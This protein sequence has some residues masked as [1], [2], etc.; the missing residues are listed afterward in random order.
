MEISEIINLDDNIIIKNIKTIDK[1]KLD[2]YLLF[3]LVLFKKIDSIKYVLDNDLVRLDMLDREGKTILYNIIKFNYIDL[4]DIILEKNKIL[5]GIDLN[6]VRDLN[7]NISLNYTIIFNNIEM[8]K[9]LILLFDPYIKNKLNLNSFE[10]SVK[11]KKYNI[12]LMLVDKY[13][14]FRFVNNNNENILFDLI[15]DNQLDIIKTLIKRENIK[16]D[17]NLKNKEFSLTPLVVALGNNYSDIALL[18][19]E[20]GSDIN[21]TDNFGNTGLHYLLIENNINIFNIV[22]EYL[23]NKK[24]DI[25]YDIQ[26][27]NGNT[28]LHLILLNNLENKINVNILETIIKNTN[29]NLLNQDSN[30]VLL[31]IIKNKLLLRFIDIIKDKDMNFLLKIDDRFYLDLLNEEELN[32][33]LPILKNNYYKALTEEDLLELLNWEKQC[34]DIKKE[35]KECLDLIEKEIKNRIKLKP[36]SKQN[37]KLDNGILINVND[38]NN[39]YTGSS[40]DIIYGLIYL[41]KNYSNIT[42]FLEYPLTVNEE[43]ELFYKRLNIDYPFN[44]DFANFEII[45]I[46]NNLFIPNGLEIEKIK[47][48][49]RFYVIPIA[50]DSSEFSHANML[51]I[52]NE[53][54]LIERFEPFGINGPH[55][56]FY[57]SNLLDDNLKESFE[58]LNYKYKKPIDYLPAVSFQAL[59]NLEKPNFKKIGDPNGFCAIWCSW[60]VDMKLKY[61]FIDSKSLAI[62]LLEQFKIDKIVLSDFIRD[63]SYNIT[64]LRDEILKKNNIDINDWLNG[65]YTQQILD[66]I[67]KDTFNINNNF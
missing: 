24:V 14:D 66:N 48:N 53:N 56:F 41:S 29:L 27:L 26:N 20:N 61:S 25:L 33:I 11:L 44:M 7:G 36:T 51:I 45:W 2:K 16:I 39:Y 42:Y 35:K 62:K 23:I 63:Y 38:G 65:N 40:I 13:E 19:V 55:G 18:L 58:K 52:D 54:K 15:K 30:S 67:E 5:L 60:W 32:I 64:K 34:R 50:L 4:L 10:M 12:F 37:F 8:F 17:I 46:N 22:I 3:D 43:L 49:K 1:D 21:I 47:K 28:I 9:K 57:N 31:L 59:E 6:N